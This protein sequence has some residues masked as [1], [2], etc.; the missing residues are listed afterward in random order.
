MHIGAREYCSLQ[1]NCNSMASIPRPFLSS[2]SS[3]QVLLPPHRVDIGD[4][5]KDDACVN[6]LATHGPEP[7]SNTMNALPT[8]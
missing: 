2:L 6:H 8:K 7:L 4:P 1:C 3:L 5:H